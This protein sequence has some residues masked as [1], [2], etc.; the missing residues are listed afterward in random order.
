MP[1][2]MI[3]PF[4]SGLA[5]GAIGAA[6]ANSNSPVMA[7]G[8]LDSVYIKHTINPTATT[9][10]IVNGTFAVDANWTK[11]LGWT[12]PVSQ[13]ATATAAAANLSAAVNPLTIASMYYVVYTVV[14]TTGSVRFTD[15]VNTGIT[16]TVSG[17]YAEVFTA[18]AAGF[19]FEPVAAFT[20]TIDNVAAYEY[21]PHLATEVVVSTAGLTTP[22][23][24]ILTVTGSITDAWIGMRT[25][26]Q[27]T[28][29]V[30]LIALTIYEPFPVYDYI[31]VKI[32][33]AVAGDNID[34]WLMINCSEETE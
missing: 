34:V 1:I 29:G 19:A 4:N 3:G 2:S 25:I 27:N 5:V 21:D 33:S 12:I 22:T 20:G 23:Y 15:G 30:D 7:K 28:L 24:T 14:V 32:D 8:F 18:G 26:P 6:T 11:G 10:V 16:R 17:T 13:K 9:D 31:N